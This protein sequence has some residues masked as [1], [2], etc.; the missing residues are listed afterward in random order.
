MLVRRLVFCEASIVLGEKGLQLIMS[1]AQQQHQ[2]MAGWKQF[3]D[4]ERRLKYVV[5]TRKY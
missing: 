5:R 4:R 2:V 3:E 1:H